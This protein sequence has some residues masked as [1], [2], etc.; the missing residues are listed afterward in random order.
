MFRPTSK[1]IYCASDPDGVLRG[2]KDYT[3][4]DR[5]SLRPVSSCC[6]TSTEFVVGG[7]KLARE[8]GSSQVSGV[9][10]CVCSMN[11]PP[12]SGTPCFPFYI[13]R[14]SRDYSRREEG[15]RKRKQAPRGVSFSSSYGSH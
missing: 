12:F 8:G 7:Y 5:M 11:R 3:S 15:K 9:M 6:V 2:H 10:R 14:E 1:F 4:S 13:P